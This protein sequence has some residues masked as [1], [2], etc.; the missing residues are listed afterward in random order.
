[1]YLK[2]HLSCDISVLVNIVTTLV[3]RNWSC[4]DE[5]AIKKE[6]IDIFFKFS[7]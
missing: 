6:N 4:N 3:R 1:M 5:I 2:V 7:S